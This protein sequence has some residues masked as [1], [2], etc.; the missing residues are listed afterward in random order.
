MKYYIDA[1]IC[2]EVLSKIIHQKEGAALYWSLYKVVLEFFLPHV[3]WQQGTAWRK[4]EHGNNLR[5]C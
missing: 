2:G 3:A 5:Q 4:R 1:H